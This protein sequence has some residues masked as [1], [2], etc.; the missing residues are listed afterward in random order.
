[1]LAR[2]LMLHEKG[3]VAARAVAQP[4]QKIFLPT[5]WALTLA[6]RRYAS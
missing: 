1:M 5:G 6:Y 2:I 3:D 4:F